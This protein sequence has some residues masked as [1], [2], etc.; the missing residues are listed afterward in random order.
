MLPSKDVPRTSPEVDRGKEGHRYPFFE[1]IPRS[2]LILDL[3][4]L[5]SGSFDVFK[6]DPAGFAKEAPGLRRQNS[7]NV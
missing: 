5:L 2:P 6:P 7:F 3:L 1:K 4:V